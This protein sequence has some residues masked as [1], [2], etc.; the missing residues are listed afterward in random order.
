MLFQ[1]H[2]VRL[3]GWGTETPQES[4]SFQFHKVRLKAINLFL[5]NEIQMF[6]FHKVRLKVYVK[7]IY[8]TYFIVSIP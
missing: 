1:F 3:K 6:Q 2:K 5:L 7:M 8:V 4:L